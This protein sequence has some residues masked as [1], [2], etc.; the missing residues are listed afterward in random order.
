LFFKEE[1]KTN[2][3]IKRR[4]REKAGIVPRPAF[5]QKGTFSSSSSTVFRPLRKGKKVLTLFLGLISAF[6]EKI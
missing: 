3:L 1:E 5:L 6:V 2:H 4:R